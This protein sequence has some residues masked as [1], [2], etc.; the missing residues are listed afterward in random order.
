MSWSASSAQ[1]TASASHKA[2]LVHESE[3][4]AGNDHREAQIFQTILPDHAE[5]TRS[6]LQPHGKDEQSETDGLHCCVELVA[7]V[8]KKKAAKKKPAK[9]KAAKKKPAKKKPAKKA[10]KKK[11]AKKSKTKKGKKPKS[12]T[13]KDKTKKKGKGK[14]KKNKKGVQ[15]TPYDS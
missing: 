1:A 5:K 13:G 3:S 4:G 12:K 9:K 10:A 2:H 6:G 11:P 7:E 14:K 15:C 8:A